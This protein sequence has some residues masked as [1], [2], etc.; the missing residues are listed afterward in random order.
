MAEYDTSSTEFEV[1]MEVRLKYLSERDYDYTGQ[2]A[3]IKKIITG[4]KRKKYIVEVV[5]HNVD[6]AVNEILKVRKQNMVKHDG[7]ERPQFRYISRHIWLRDVA[8]SRELC[9]SILVGAYTQVAM[10]NIHQKDIDKLK[11]Y[12]D[13]KAIPFNNRTSKEDLQNSI[14]EYITAEVPFY[15]FQVEGLEMYKFCRRDQCFF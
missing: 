15:I 5:D 14:E 8:A 4:K 11:M 13:I 9:E 1:G 7:L 12:C 6:G 3:T 10:V 2:I